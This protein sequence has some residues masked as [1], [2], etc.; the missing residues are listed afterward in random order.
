M[1]YLQE[2]RRNEDTEFP[3]MTFIRL[4]LATSRNR[5]LCAKRN[6]SVFHSRLL[7]VPGVVL[8]DPKSGLH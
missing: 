3:R 5:V 7:A 8:T 6:G 2:W 1:L 4:L